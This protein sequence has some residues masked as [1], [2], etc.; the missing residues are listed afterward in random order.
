MNS[1]L[2]SS[3]SLQG[4]SLFFSQRSSSGQSPA[5]R[6]RAP[7]SWL[8]SSYFYNGFV[9]TWLTQYFVSYSPLLIS[10][11]QLTCRL[12]DLELSPRSSPTLLVS[13]APSLS[14]EPSCP[15]T[16]MVSDTDD[17]LP[18]RS[19]IHQ[20]HQARQDCFCEFDSSGV[21]LYPGLISGL[22]RHYSRRHLDLGS[23][24]TKAI[25]RRS[26]Q[27]RIRL[28][29]RRFRKGLC[30]G[31]LLA[32]CRTGVPAVPLLGCRPVRYRLV[33]SLQAHG[34]LEGFRGSRSDCRLG[35][36]IRVSSAT[37]RGVFR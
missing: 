11:V 21:Q 20:H 4:E 30:L 9:S 24:P 13:S 7:N 22:H 14:G 2:F 8:T 34:Y 1:G 32:I 10:N 27:A 31:L 29:S 33:I 12:S 15:T 19:S 37:R 5:F 26:H 35:V 25:L 16:P 36:S 18:A 28:V 3:S 23:D 6:S 17:Q